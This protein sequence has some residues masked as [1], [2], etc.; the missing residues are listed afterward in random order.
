M[1]CICLSLFQ[2]CIDLCLDALVCEY[3]GGADWRGKG[4]V[5]EEGIH[6]AAQSG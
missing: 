4:A 2:R 3:P 6:N 1:P 5:E